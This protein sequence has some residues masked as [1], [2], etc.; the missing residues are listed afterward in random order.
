MDKLRKLG[1]RLWYSKERLVF[2]SL[3]AVLIWNVYKVA[4]AAEEPD[5]TKAVRIIKTTDDLEPVRAPLPPP[6]PPIN[7]WKSIYTPNPFWYTPGA[8]TVAQDQKKQVD[9]KLLSIQPGRDGYRVRLQ[10]GNN[11]A[12]H[13]VGGAFESYEVIS[14][15]PD[16]GTCQVRSEGDGSI[17]TLSISG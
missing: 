1:E 2:V 11:R 14:I 15:D 16:A 13:S 12:W 9:I 5:E 4:T 7:D 17:L 10:S 6:P 8:G 3:V